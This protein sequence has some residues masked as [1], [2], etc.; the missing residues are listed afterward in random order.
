MKG[1]DPEA[2]TVDE[3]W[4]VHEKIEKVLCS[5][6]LSEQER[7]DAQMSRLRTG[8][9]RLTELR[10]PVVA[11]PAA[12]KDATARRPY[13]EVKPKYRSLKDPSQTWAGRGKQP[14][15]LIAEMKGGKTLEDFLIA[16]KTGARKK[17]R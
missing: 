1:F 16:S 9:A 4:Q 13:P 12:P 6:I 14:R 2:M 8:P 11:K 17:A 10:R 7:L 5:K 15:W 3:L